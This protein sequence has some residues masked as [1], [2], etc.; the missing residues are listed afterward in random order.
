MYLKN[1]LVKFVIDVQME[2][3]GL[4][5]IIGRSFIPEIDLADPEMS[6]IVGYVK[7]VRGAITDAESVIGVLSMKLAACEHS[8]I[9]DVDEEVQILE[10]FSHMASKIK[11][12]LIPLFIN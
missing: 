9:G 2:I 6:Q 10:E 8:A 5:K 11:P 1:H 4:N 12:N 7:E 3:I